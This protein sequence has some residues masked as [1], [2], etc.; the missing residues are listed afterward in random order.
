[1]EIFKKSEPTR[2]CL[3]LTAGMGKMVEN[4]CCSNAANGSQYYSTLYYSVGKYI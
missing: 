1:M 4:G 3:S 2:N